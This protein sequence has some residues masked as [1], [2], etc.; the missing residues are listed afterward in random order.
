MINV[1]S[2]DNDWDPYAEL[3]GNDQELEEEIKIFEDTLGNTK[4]ASEDSSSSSNS[5]TLGHST[6]Q[7]FIET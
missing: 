5:I 4:S 7:H 1:E 2:V 6:V 3:L